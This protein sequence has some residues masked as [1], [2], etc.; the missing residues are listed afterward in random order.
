MA[1]SAG[2]GVGWCLLCLPWVVGGVVAPSPALPALGGGVGCV[3]VGG[4]VAPSA[5]LPALG[6]GVGCVVAWVAPAALPA[7]PWV[8]VGGGGSCCPACCPACP[9][10]TPDT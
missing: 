8:V 5:A 6:G 4:V 10:D 7:L 2:L 1:G 9:A 3:V